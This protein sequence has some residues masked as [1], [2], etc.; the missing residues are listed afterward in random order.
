MIILASETISRRRNLPVELQYIT[1]G[2]DLK[3]FLWFV[4]HSTNGGKYFEDFEDVKEYIRQKKL[5]SPKQLEKIEGIKTRLLNSAKDKI[6]ELQH[7]EDIRNT[8]EYRGAKE[9]LEIKKQLHSDFV[10]GE[11][12]A[13]KLIKLHYLKEIGENLFQIVQE[14]Q[15]R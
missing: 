5:L 1:V 14:L 9:I 7:I 11:D 8:P 12:V 13:E 4:D 6:K 2:N 15:D 3:N 10:C